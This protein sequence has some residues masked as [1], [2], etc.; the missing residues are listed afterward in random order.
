[1]P[2]NNNNRPSTYGTSHISRSR[3]ATIARQDEALRLRRAGFTYVEIARQL[4]FTPNGIARPQ[5]AAEAV[6]AAERRQALANGAVSQVASQTTVSNGNFVSNRTFGIEAEFYGITPQR[7]I[8]ALAQVGITATYEG[9]THRNTGHWKIVTDS[10]V[11]STGTGIGYGLEL[12]SPILR[13]RQGVEEIIKALDAIRLAGGKVNK[14]CGLHTHIG[15]DGLTG[16]EMMKVIDTY[17]AN[18]TNINRIVSRSRHNNGYCLPFT[19]TTQRNSYTGN[20]NYQAVRNANNASATRQ[21]VSVFASS[22]RYRV[23]N[24]QS[25]SRYGTLE[26][27]QHQGTLNGRKASAWVLFLLS[28]VETASVASSVTAYGSCAEMF[29]GVGVD[30]S[31]SNYLVRRESTL[32]PTVVVA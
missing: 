20:N 13:G 27:R 29:A 6:R 28:L 19:E 32:N 18:Q 1:M 31:T 12:V 22:P 10:S 17:V 11:T 16:M 8:D 24:T 15:M 25:Y 7:A 5:S 3:R 4:G 30:T 21:A 9:Y 23:V 2:T 26:F 14:T